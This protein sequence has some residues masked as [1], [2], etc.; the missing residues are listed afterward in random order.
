MKKADQW[1]GVFLLAVAIAICWGS[2][3]MPY[4]E[5]HSPGPGF[6]PFW[7]GMLL[8]AMALGLVVASTL[9][10]SEGK[11]LADILREKVRRNNVL[12]VLGALIL[13]GALLDLI[14]FLIGTLLLMVLLLRYVEPQP[15]K[16]VMGWAVGGTL[17]A[18]AVFEVW[19]KLRLPKGILGF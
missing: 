15:W 19:M 16:A 6:Y 17:V 11:D 13:Y 1:S 14:G 18:Y 9:N 8:G 5:L 4:G 12:L 7:L 3:Q 10:A 2:L